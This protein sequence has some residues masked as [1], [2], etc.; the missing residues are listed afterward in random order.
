M[1]LF[2]DIETVPSQ[3]SDAKEGIVIEAPGNYKKPES[4]A[5]W[6]EENTESETEKVYHKFGFDGA[7]GEIICIGFAFDDD[8][9]QIIGREKEG[10][11]AALLTDFFKTLN[12]KKY[13]VEGQPL[14]ITWVGHYITGF[15][16][17]FIWQR[18]VANNV[19]PLIT[20]PYNAKPWDNEVFD[21]MVEWTG[22]KKSGIGKLDAICKALGHEGKGDIDGSQVWEYIKAGRYEEIFNYCKSDV[23]LTRFLYRKMTFKF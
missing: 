7:L 23:E 17:R 2:I 5:K 12:D 1:N 6:L 18:C 20:I 10:G 16:L 21:T 13:A 8:E 22:V 3:K 19:K 9:P 14:A 4:I 15:D 11:E